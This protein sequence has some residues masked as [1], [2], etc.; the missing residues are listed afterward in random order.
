[1]KKVFMTYKLFKD[2]IRLRECFD[3]L[4]IIQDSSGHLTL[5]ER[6]F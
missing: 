1:M 4:N 6:E 5:I 2:F 3:D